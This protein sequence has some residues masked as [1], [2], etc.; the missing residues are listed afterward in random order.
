MCSDQGTESKGKVDGEI[1]AKY[2]EETLEQETAELRRLIDIVSTSVSIRLVNGE[3][4]SGSKLTTTELELFAMKIPAECLRIQSSLNRYTANNVFRDISLETRVTEAISSMIGTKGNA[5]E[6]KR[7]AE[8]LVVDERTVSAANK[9]IVK[10]LQAYIDRADKVYE[11]IKKVMDFRA[12]EGWF[13]R[14]GTM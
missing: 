6:R 3:I 12:R 4:H 1:M 14:K 2:V 9:A 5:E 8:L 10:G 7:K 11:G 13:D